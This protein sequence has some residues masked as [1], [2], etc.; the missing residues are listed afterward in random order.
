MVIA[1]PKRSSLIVL[2]SD[3]RALF[4]ILEEK[5][6]A[7]LWSKNISAYPFSTSIE[8]PK[9]TPEPVRDMLRQTYKEAG[10]NVSF[11]VGIE[12]DRHLFCLDILRGS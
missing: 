9:E 8:I 7:H 10:W 12:E 6:D 11:T 1:A 2:S 3:Q 4:E 5:V